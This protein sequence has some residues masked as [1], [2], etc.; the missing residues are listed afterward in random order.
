MPPRPASKGKKGKKGKA[1]AEE[2][3]KG[4]ARKT[5]NEDA[6]VGSISHILRTLFREQYETAARE[7]EEV[8]A[9]KGFRLRSG[10]S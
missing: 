2:E 3:E 1:E 10:E 9:A 5:H 7:M 6:A 4:P 8:V